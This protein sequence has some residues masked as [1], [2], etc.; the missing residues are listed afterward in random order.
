MHDDAASGLIESRVES[1]RV[2]QYNHELLERAHVVGEPE[3]FEQSVVAK[4]AVRGV[5]G[6]AED[7]E[8]AELR[9][10]AI[11]ERRKRVSVE[12]VVT[13]GA[14]AEYL[15]QAVEGLWWMIEVFAA[16]GWPQT[17]R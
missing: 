3:R 10:G 11:G 17:Q 9:E 13:E 12:G 16:M 2:E 6:A 1:A 8:L 5:G 14:Q 7:R 4:E 15:Q